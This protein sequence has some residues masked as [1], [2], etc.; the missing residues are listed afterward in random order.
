MRQ[1]CQGPGCA[2]L[3][4]EAGVRGG[5]PRRYC[6]ERCRSSSR[7]FLA[8]LDRCL[9]RRGA[10]LE[11]MAEERHLLRSAAYT[12]AN[13]ARGLAAV[14]DAEAG[15]PGWEQPAWWDRARPELGRPGAPYTRAALEL[16]EAAHLAVAAAVAA[17]RAPGDGWAEI[18]A[19]LGVSEDTA[20]R[21]Y[22]RA[23]DT[24]P[25]DR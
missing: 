3:L 6:S 2:E 20:A 1:R 17:D 7:R 5:R 18:G 19:A 15:R 4:P 21:R 10:R 11:T 9:A 16:L 25:P 24:P 14:L 13:E 22:R 12:V 23:A 8:L